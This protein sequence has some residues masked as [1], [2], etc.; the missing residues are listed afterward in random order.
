MFSRNSLGVQ[1]TAASSLSVG[2][3]FVLHRV[4]AEVTSALQAISAQLAEV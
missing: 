3:M 4:R 2:G 1:S